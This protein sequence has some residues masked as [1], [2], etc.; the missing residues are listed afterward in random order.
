MEQLPSANEVN[1]FQSAKLHEEVFVE[2]ILNHKF[3]YDSLDLVVVDELVLPN[4]I[5]EVS[6]QRLNVAFVQEGTEK[7][8][9]KLLCLSLARPEEIT[10]TDQQP[11]NSHVPPVL[12]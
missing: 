6:Y 1:I 7:V 2:S 10:R 9:D 5:L 12:L 3:I 8:R 11:M 4:L